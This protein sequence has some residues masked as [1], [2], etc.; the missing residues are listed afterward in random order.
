MWSLVSEQGYPRSGL[1]VWACVARSTVYSSLD[2]NCYWLT[3]CGHIWASLLV[4]R[5]SSEIRTWSS[6][7]L[8]ELHS[9][10]YFFCL[11]SSHLHHIGPILFEVNIE[12][13]D[14][15]AYQ[16]RISNSSCEQQ[17]LGYPVRRLDKRCL[18]FKYQVLPMKIPPRKGSDKDPVAQWFQS[19]L[20]PSLSLFYLQ[21]RSMFRS[22]VSN[23]A[24][25]PFTIG[26]I[27]DIK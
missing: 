6:Y 14:H 8:L 7:L 2:W 17:N 16:L 12:N 25:C 21:N 22:P 5:N 11:L 15:L 23:P 1:R 27:Q 3:E 10:W 13:Y 18:W 9:R 19:M 26:L 4:F 24:S 20:K